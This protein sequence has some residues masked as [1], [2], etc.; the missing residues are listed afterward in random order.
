MSVPFSV[1]GAYVGDCPV[2][3]FALCLGSH[4]L[5]VPGAIY[6]GDNI[7]YFFNSFYTLHGQYYPY[8]IT[9][10][11]DNPTVV[12]VQS[13]DTFYA[14]YDECY[15]DTSVLSVVCSEGGHVTVAGGCEFASG[16]FAV[17]SG[18]YVTATPVADEGYTFSG[19]ALNGWP[20]GNDIPLDLYMDN[21]YTL[22]AVFT[23]N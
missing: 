15:V 2:Y 17:E 22:Y 9:Y 21:D 18:A 16:C 8:T 11:Y 7:W 1:D 5:M 19:W 14:L 20:I 13:D 10:Y 3:E 23:Q 12:D 4:T 6:A